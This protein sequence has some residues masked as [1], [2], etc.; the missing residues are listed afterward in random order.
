[1]TKA[2]DFAMMVGRSEAINPTRVALLDGDAVTVADSA[3]V[4]SIVGN[5]GAAVYDSL[6]A[7]PVAGLTAGQQ[8]FVSANDRLYISNGNGWYNVALINATPRLTIDPTGA[9]TLAT[10]GTTPTVITLTGID[11]DNADASL[12]YSVDSDGNFGGLATLS[13]DSSVFTITPLGEDSATTET[14]TLTFKVSDGVNFGSGTTTFTLTFITI[15]ANSAGT[16]L[17]FKADTAGTDNQVDASTNNHTITESGNVTSTAFTPYHPGGYSVAFAGSDDYLGFDNGYITTN[18]SWWNSSGFT[19]ELW[20]YKTVSTGATGTV[21][22]NRQSGTTGFLLTNKNTGWDMY[23]N[24][25]YLFQNAGTE[26]VGQ[27]VHLALVAS[28]TTVTLYENGT[29]LY[30]TGSAP[31]TSSYGYFGR[32]QNTVGAVQYTPRGTNVDWPGYMYDIRISSGS[33]YTTAF[34]PPET[35]HE[36]DSNTILLAC[37][38]PMLK[39]KSS[40]NHQI[41]VFGDGISTA[42]F[43]PH[44]YDPYTKAEFGGSVY[45]DGSGDYLV[46]A[47]TTAVGTSDFTLEGWFYPTSTAADTT[48]FDFRSSG[49]WGIFSILANNTVGYYNGSSSVGI[50]SNTVTDNIWNHI[51]IVRNSGS[52]KI[53]IN[54]VLGSTTAD[55]TNWT[56]AASPR[57]GGNKGNVAWMNGYI[58]DVR[59]VS[60]TAVYTSA[61]TPP[62]APLT[63]ITNTQLLTCTNKNDIWDASTGNLLT[64]AGNTTASNTQRQ[65][66]SSSAI[67]FDGSG[68]Y[69]TFAPGSRFAFGTGDFTIE[70]W[71]Y[72]DSSIV[73]QHIIDARNS[74]QTTNWVFGWAAGTSNGTLG[75]YTGSTT[76]TMGSSWQTNRWYHLAVTREGTTL[77]GFVDGAQVNSITDSRNYNVSPT[78]SY[79]GD[80]YS[81]T[82]QFTGYIQ[83]LRVTKGLAR[84]TSNFTPPTVEFEG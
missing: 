77:K 35:P 19:L 56:L 75:Y 48:I 42:R 78:T 30:T 38:S 47:I 34:T 31:N 65:F 12:T 52:I 82:N 20:F 74:S 4:S 25:A 6:G 72:L 71:V 64:K 1:M 84:Y 9:V 5:A 45:F 70:C 81:A 23:L 73:D 39:D 60:G 8:A 43:T 68:D 55:T 29:S 51:A 24:G 79:I 59:F 2:R 26:K 44:D 16:T 83:D 40:N 37:S 36:N 46:P 53:Y 50:T 15:V 63:A 18:G 13:Q 27:W 7:L 3:T 21:F 57:I 11:S 58:A 62:T 76:M 22:D 67:Y 61:F 80:R 10:D 32:S 33:R 28:G 66:T 14:S 17:L 69:L 41:T 54:G 49:N